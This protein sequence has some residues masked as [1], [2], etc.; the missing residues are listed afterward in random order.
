LPSLDQLRTFLAVYRAGTMTAAAGALHLSQPSVSAHLHAL[1]EEVGTPLFVRHA[2]GVEP[3]ARGLTLARAVSDPLDQLAA[4]EAGLL[5][6][7]VEETVVVGGP[8]DLVSL[9]ALP[10]LTALIGTGIRLRLRTGLAE[11]LVDVLVAGELDVAIAV[12]QPQRADLV[13]E[14]LFAETLVLVGAPSWRGRLP[15]GSL[16]DDAAAALA[17]VPWL[18]LNEDL[19]FISD[20]CRA[21]FG[22]WRPRSVAAVAVA[23]LRALARLAETGAGVA[24]LPDYVVEQ[25]LAAGTL[26]QL[27]RPPDPPRQQIALAYRPATLRRPG[28][29]AVRDA[30]RAASQAWGQA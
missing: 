29:S 21:A 3:T 4:V 16:R 6:G 17:E 7:K 10:A 28:V 1:E 23:D 12:R 20:Y 18:A 26:V 14:P 19:P 11:E 25:E 5:A 30:L 22:G 15:A 9:R 27:H 2:R 24:V 13:Y 8:L